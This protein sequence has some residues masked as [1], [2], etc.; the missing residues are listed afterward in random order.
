MPWGSKNSVP[1][2]WRSR[3]APEVSNEQTTAAQSDRA[4]T[5]GLCTS[6]QARSWA[7]RSQESSRLICTSVRRRSLAVMTTIT[8]SAHSRWS[9]SHSSPRATGRDIFNTIQGFGSPFF[10]QAGPELGTVAE[11]EVGIV[12]NDQAGLTGVLDLRAR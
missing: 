10:K 12:E 2:R 3:K 1:R 8:R 5:R 7:V 4:L 9:R 6:S 11:P